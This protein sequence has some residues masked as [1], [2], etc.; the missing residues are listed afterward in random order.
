MKIESPYKI[1]ICD[2]HILFRD[3]V[4][5]LIETEKIGTVIAQA[6]N[7]Q[8]FLNII[9]NKKPDVVLMDIDMPIMGG[10]E[11]TQKATKKYPDIKSL[12]FLCLA[13]KYCILK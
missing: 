2:D 4:K 7:G 13:K 8:E 5:L 6:E 12:F 11:A 10:I 1:I 9:E 3:G